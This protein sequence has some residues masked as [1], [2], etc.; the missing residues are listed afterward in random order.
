[1][2]RR[3]LAILAAIGATIIYA[4]NHTIAKGVMPNHVQPFGFIMLRVIGASI[5]F[6][7]VS[8]FGPKEKIE[9]KDYPR[10]FICALLGMGLNMLVFFKGLSLSTPI[11]SAVL[12]TTTPIIVV[13]L[14]AVLIK[15]KIIPQ[16]MIG[17]LIGLLGALGLIFFGTELRADAPNI[18]LGNFLI[19]M[20]SVFYG[21]YLIGAKTLIAKYHPFTFMK[22]L[23][24]IG[25]FI[26]LPFGYHELM[27]IDWPN[28]PFEALWKIAFVVLG[29]TFCT[30]LFNI[31]ALTQLKASTLSAFV[32]IQPLIG[33][34]FAVAT[35]QDKLT[36]LKILA[37]CLV[38]LG[39]YLASKKPKP[40]PLEP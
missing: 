5:L 38:F 11:N 12:I 2:S 37:G 33:I 32:Y 31:F 19:F 16:K 13:L 25:I 24:T 21:S 28:L 40:N 17:I 7:S 4:L 39:V 6:W 36:T 23:F 9:K 14:S 22:W 10:M 26:C 3:T 15:E 18:P 20:N 34:L 8:F 27:A 30:Y 29:T 35:G 1:M